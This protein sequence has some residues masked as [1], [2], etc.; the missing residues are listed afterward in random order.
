MF[1]GNFTIAKNLGKKLEDYDELF[2]NILNEKYENIFKVDN[3]FISFEQIERVFKKAGFSSVKIHFAEFPKD[4]TPQ[5][6]KRIKI[7]FDEYDT[8]VYEMTK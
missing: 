3:W 8:V 7:F 6:E 5:E 2:F 1:S 4:L